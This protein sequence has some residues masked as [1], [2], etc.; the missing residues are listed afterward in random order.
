MNVLA[1]FDDNGAPTYQKLDQKDGQAKLKNSASSTIAN[2]ILFNHYLRRKQMLI[3]QTKTKMYKEQ[4]RLVKEYTQK[5]IQDI[6]SIHY[7]FQ[8]IFFVHKFNRKR[9]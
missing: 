7:L 5:R 3:D 2:F 6:N 8:M 9:M 1:Q 4:D